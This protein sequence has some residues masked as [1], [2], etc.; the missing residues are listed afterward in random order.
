MQFP[1]DAGAG[2]ADTTYT[3]ILLQDAITRAN[4]HCH[5]GVGTTNNI[6][7]MLAAAA[8]A[9]AAGRHHPRQPVL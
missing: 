9:A 4:L 3:I 7:V 5:D 6:V 2:A 8:A 1:A